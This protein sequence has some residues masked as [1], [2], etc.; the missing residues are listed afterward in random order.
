MS[1]LHLSWLDVKGKRLFKST[2]TSFSCL[3]RHWEHYKLSTGNTN[4]KMVD[5]DDIKCVKIPEEELTDFE[6]KKIEHFEPP[7][8]L[9]IDDVNEGWVRKYIKV[10]LFSYLS[11]FLRLFRFIKNTKILITYLV[12]SE[13]CTTNKTTNNDQKDNYTKS[14]Q[15]KR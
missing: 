7:K 14:K 13:S 4:G 12:P 5:P 1:A 9:G 3:R 10:L 2:R 15:R 8:Q 6:K 11:F